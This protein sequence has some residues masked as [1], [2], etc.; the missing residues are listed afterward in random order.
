LAEERT[1]RKLAAVLAADIVGFSRMMEADEAGTLARVKAL[2]ADLLHP[3]VA[4]YG[5]R[6]VKFTGD[7]ALIEFPSAVDAVQHAL[8]VQREMAR[9]NAAESDGRRIDLR[10]GINIGDIIIDGD[11]IYGDGVNV[12]ARLE[13]IAEPGGICVSGTVHDYVRGKVDAQFRDMGAQTLKN[14]AKPVQVYGIVLDREE[15]SAETKSAPRLAL[16]SKPSIAVLAFQNMSGDPE[17]EYFAD[18]IAEDVIT[19]LS[20]SR[21]LFVVARNSSFTYKNRSVDVRQIGR[22]LGVRYVL[23]GSVR[24]AGSRVR[25]TAQLVDALNGHHVWADRYDRG[26]EDIFAVQDEMT[27]QIASAIAPGIVAAEVQRVQAKSPGELGNWERLMRAHW[28]IQRFNRD[29]FREAIRLLDDLTRDDPSNATALSDLA[30]AWH[31][32][33]SFAWADDPAVAFASCGDAVA[34]RDQRR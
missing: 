9:R 5:G 22:E 8:E 14:I 31:F 30:F 6:L 18:G 11:D 26:L 25:I 7:G 33:G 4:A 10:M 21:W 24:K 1:Q 32:T 3:K 28:H 2:R 27:S 19:A 20:R 16:P 34:A 13:G 15:A 29:D 12:A 17:Q 23:E